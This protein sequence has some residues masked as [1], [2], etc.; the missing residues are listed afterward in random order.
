MKDLMVTSKQTS[1]C[2]TIDVYS[3]K[4]VQYVNKIDQEQKEANSQKS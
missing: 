4:E 3:A 2:M 1:S